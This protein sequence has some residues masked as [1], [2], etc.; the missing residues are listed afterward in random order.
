[1]SARAVA[2]ALRKSTGLVGLRKVAEPRKE[3]I[4][5]YSSTLE[6]LKKMPAAAAYRVNVEALTNERLAIAQSHEAVEAIED[7]VDC[8]QI[9]EVLLQAQRE[10]D[11]AEKMN[12]W[13]PWES[14]EEQPTADQW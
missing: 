4:S 9:E 12:E 10:L 5:V 2:H 11:L 3:L 14:L 13:K 8:G 1:M 7:A 6:V